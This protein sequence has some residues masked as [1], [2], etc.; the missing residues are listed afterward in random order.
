[1]NPALEPTQWRALAAKHRHR[2]EAHTQPVRDRRARGVR[3]PVGDFLFQYYPYPISLLE[4]W[5]PGI[6]VVLVVE[7]GWENEFSADLHHFQN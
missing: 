5:H 7:E 3:D 2:A 6:G 1:M 4:R